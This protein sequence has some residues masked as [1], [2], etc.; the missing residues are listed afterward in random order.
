MLRNKRAK[1]TLFEE[2]QFQKYLVNRKKIKEKSNH[3]ERI[4]WKEKEFI[5]SMNTPKEKENKNAI[6]MDWDEE[7]DLSFYKQ[8]GKIW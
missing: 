4:K 2:N 3:Y 6:V 7:V 5:E 8:L 1:R